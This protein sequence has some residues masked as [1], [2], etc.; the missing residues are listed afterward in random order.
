LRGGAHTLAAQ[1]STEEALAREDAS[2]VFTNIE[3]DG[4]SLVTDAEA[5]KWSRVVD[6]VHI[7]AQKDI[8]IGNQVQKDIG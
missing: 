7:A 6:K 2:E 4:M 3:E 1:L 5:A 8:D